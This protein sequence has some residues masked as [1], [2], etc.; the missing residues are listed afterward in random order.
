MG[1]KCREFNSLRGKMGMKGKK[2]YGSWNK[3]CSWKK[4]LHATNTHIR[5]DRR[6]K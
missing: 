2:L 4:S 6:E 1:E 3:N 5:G